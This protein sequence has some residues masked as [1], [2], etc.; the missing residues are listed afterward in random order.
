[1]SCVHPSLHLQFNSYRVGKSS[2]VR[3][4]IL[5]P[6]QRY[7]SKIIPRQ[8]RP[9]PYLLSRWKLYN[10]FIYPKV[11]L[12]PRIFIIA[13]YT[14]NLLCYEP[15][16]VCLMLPSNTSIQQVES[17]LLLVELGTCQR[18][19]YF[20][21]SPVCCG[22]AVAMTVQWLCDD[23][24]ITVHNCA[25]TVQSDASSVQSKT[26]ASHTTNCTSFVHALPYQS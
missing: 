21:V 10:G 23:R 4:K 25:M 12:N 11:F 8:L 18:Q 6:E 2:S 22:R 9:S 5:P 14:P 26:S 1:M 17:I 3:T 19:R 13:L 7:I 20:D 15:W 24:A 16:A